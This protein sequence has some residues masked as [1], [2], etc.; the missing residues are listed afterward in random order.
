MATHLKPFTIA[1]PY[2]SLHPLHLQ[3][4]QQPRNR[5]QT[6]W[7]RFKIRASSS[8]LDMWKKAIERE[9]NTTNFNKLASSNDNN[10]EENLEKKTE[11]FQKLLQVSSEERDRIQRLQV[12]DRASAAIAAARALLKDAN[13]NSVRSDKD[14]LQKNESDSGKKNDSIFVQE[15]GTQNGTLF[16]PKSGTQKDG[17]PGPDFWSWTPP[18]DSD[19]PSNDANG[20]KLNPKSSVNPTL[21]NP[22][23]EKERSSQSLSIP[24]ESLLTQSKTFPTLPPLQSSLEVV[25]ASASNVESPSLEE[26]LKRGA[27]SSD[28]AAEVVRAL[29]TDS[30]SSPV[31]VN[32]DGTRWWRETGIEQRPDGVI[33]RWTLIRGVSA[34]KALEWQEKFWEASDEFGYKELGSEK[35]GRDAT[36]NV[37]REFWRESMRQENGL[38]HMEKTADKWGRNG[39]GDE[40]QEK[41]FEHYNA[42][43]Q[44]EKWAHKWCSI[45]P[46]TP[47]DAGHAHVWHER[48]GETYDGYGGSIKYTDKWAE[49]SSDGGWE[50]W[51]D[52]WDENFDPNSHGIKQ[53]ETWWEGKYGERWNR[54]WGEQ[55]N[56]SG[57]VH[58]YGKS[59][60]GEHWDTHEPQD[61][62]YERFP[63]FGFFHCF[64]NSVQLREVKKPSERQEP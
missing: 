19:V 64:E 6:Q 15:S 34:D 38:M 57:W 9:R 5:K 40:W 49:R 50:K 48:W 27:L 31:G 59:S 52:K 18:A 39:Q 54:T 7:V 22:V 14:S 2:K 51:G 3:Q 53:G 44:A 37:W 62:W 17:I 11:E 45:D 13:S 12:I 47:L 60:S 10:V 16:V 24:F 33:C 26:E 25:E 8:Y 21:S 36:G 61:T 4:Q 32:V 42:S 23:V 41:W 20:L 1:T 58:K 28:H 30:K 56:G 29:E 46:N 63:H 55:H 43:G 35:S